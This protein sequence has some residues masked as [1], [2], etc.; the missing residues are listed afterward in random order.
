MSQLRSV[1]RI[2]LIAA[3][4]L[5]APRPAA[6]GRLQDCCSKQNAFCIIP[7]APGAAACNA[8]GGMFFAA[9]ACTKATKECGVVHQ[10]TA[11]GTVSL[12]TQPSGQ[13]ETIPVQG[14][15][16]VIETEMIQLELTGVGPIGPIK[17]HQSVHPSPGS[18]GPGTSSY[19]LNYDI[20]RP[21]SNPVPQHVEATGV[22]TFPPDGI[23]YNSTGAVPLHDAAGTPV[24]VVNAFSFT[25][26]P[27]ADAD[28]D[29][30][31]DAAD[32]CPG[33]GPGDRV[34]EHG[35]S[36]AQN[37][38]SP[39]D[40]DGDGVA[41]AQDRCPA[42]AAADP[43]DENGCSLAQFCIVDAT[44]A[45]GKRTCRKLDWKNDEPIMTGRDADCRVDKGA[46]GTADDRCVPNV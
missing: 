20:E 8:A 5:I 46:A 10:R 27:L 25:L 14:H 17:V 15:I 1:A 4:F 40:S 29:G 42:T 31:E 37:C 16:D 12:Q 43:V 45:L 35:C 2:A 38:P 36:A 22:M 33:T 32:A 34:D 21:V 13:S 11:T 19:D 6:A 41:D 18:L 30:V 9:N 24:G 39:P 44:T 3:A 7:Y 26:Q 23:P 28:G